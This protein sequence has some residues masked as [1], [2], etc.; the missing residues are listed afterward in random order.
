MGRTGLDESKATQVRVGVEQ[1][2]M[3]IKQQDA[4]TNVSCDAKIVLNDDGNL[5]TIPLVKIHIDA[6]WRRYVGQRSVLHHLACRG[7][8]DQ[9]FERRSEEAHSVQLPEAFVKFSN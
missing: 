7:S 3:A 5:I 4:H 1:V 2:T 9:V 8:L 6:K